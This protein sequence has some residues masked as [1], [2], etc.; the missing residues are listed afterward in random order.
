MFYYTETPTSK[1]AC[2]DIEL[3][4]LALA[5]DAPLPD[6]QKFLVVSDMALV[7]K[8]AAKT[9][10]AALVKAKNL[11]REGANVSLA[12][13]TVVIAWDGVSPYVTMLHGIFPP[14]GISMMGWPQTDVVPLPPPP[15]LG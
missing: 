5:W 3:R 2:H 8:P 9:A 14:S 15:L 1:S 11:A 13:A 6:A 4:P 7:E 10:M 12:T